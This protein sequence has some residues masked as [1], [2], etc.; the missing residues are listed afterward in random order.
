[1]SKSGVL[2]IK[3]G[4]GPDVETLTG[5]S[6]GA[7]GPDGSFNI[8]VVGSGSLVVT[9]NPGTNTL[10]ISD[11]GES[12]IWQA[13]STSQTLAVGNGYICSGGTNLSLALPAVS[14]VGSI[15]EITLDGSTSFSVTQAAGQSIKYGANV[16]TTGV[17]GSLTTT[18]Q[19]DSIRMVCSVANLR[20][21]VLSSMG[22]LT[23]V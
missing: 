5:N 4:T 19:G 11:S 23:T 15:I 3:S 21:N 22:N 9:G 8:N 1:M 13:I 7:V 16:T 18:S 17:A 10:T 2:S 20:W 12:E 6:G 14:A